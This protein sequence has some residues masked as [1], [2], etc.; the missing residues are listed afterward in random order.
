MSPSKHKKNI[1]FPLLLATGVGLLGIYVGFSIYYHNHFY[2]GTISGDVSCGNQTADWLES[3]N[4]AEAKN[5]VLTVTDR[6]GTAYPL[7]GTDFNY[8]YEPKGE[9]ALLLKKQNCLLWPI[10]IF[11]KHHLSMDRSFSYDEDALSSL[12]EN[13]TIFDRDYIEAPE[14]AHLEI[15]EDDYRIVNEIPGNTPIAEE[16]I[17]EIQNAVDAR[18]TE[19]TLSD[20][21]YTKP[22]ITAEDPVLAKTVSQID[23]YTAATVHYKI[24]GVDENLDKKA[25]LS[26]LTIT[27][28]GDVSINDAKLTDFVQRLASTYNTYGD[29][30]KF[31]TSKGDK[32]KIGGGDYGWVIDKAKEKEELLKDLNSA[33]PTERE[34]VYEQRARKSGLNDIGSTYVEIDYTNQHLWYYK[35][36]KLVTETD[37]V[38]GKTS[39]GNGSPDGVFKIAYKEKNATLIGENYSSSVKYFMP[40]A[41]N[42]GIHDASWRSQFG[43]EIYKNSG[44]HGCI[45]IPEKIAKTLYETLET[46]TPVIAYYREP[47]TLT[48]ENTKI[49]NAYSYKAKD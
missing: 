20:S 4:T 32:V 2:P 21:C 9:E 31:K 11:Q 5:Y 30:R 22:E 34:P 19:F 45:N 1:M 41:Y 8:R 33:A 35:K 48:A 39:V 18:E 10:G 24:D 13:L 49:S 28:D 42:V 16:V 37:I 46:G 47:V 26:M 23:R 38:S 17:K 44:S 14:N 3:K 36:G 43:G 15:T 29:V 6:K 25:I 12:I 40:F 27:K 7:T